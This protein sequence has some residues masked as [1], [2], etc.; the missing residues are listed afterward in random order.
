MGKYRLPLSKSGYLTITMYLRET[1][2][3]PDV[4]EATAQAIGTALQIVVW[5]D[6]EDLLIRI[7]LTEWLATRPFERAITDWRVYVN[8]WIDLL[9]TE[10][11]SDGNV[12]AVAEARALEK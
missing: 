10:R 1:Y 2:L 4:A 12:Y 9:K 7:P 8:R 6:R 3:T 5:S 11:G